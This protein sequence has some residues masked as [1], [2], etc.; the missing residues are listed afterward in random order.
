[1]TLTL[2]TD[3]NAFSMAG[4]GENVSTV[5]S[6]FGGRYYVRTTPTTDFTSAGETVVYRVDKGGDTVLDRY[7]TFMRGQQFLGWDPVN[8]KWC[9]V[10]LMPVRITPQNGMREMGQVEGLTFYAGGKRLATY[11]R[12]QLNAFGLRRQVA[13]LGN[14]LPG[15]FMVRGIEQVPATNTYLFTFDVNGADGKPVKLRFKIASGEPTVWQASTE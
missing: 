5:Q 3:A 1:M 14:R 6:A 2:P 11:S 10:H 8:G 13:H 15:D 7:P 9:V 12:S 4:Q